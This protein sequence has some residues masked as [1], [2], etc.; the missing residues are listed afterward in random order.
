MRHSFA[1]IK[2]AAGPASLAQ[3]KKFTNAI[4]QEMK[5]A[6]VAGAKLG[7][8]GAVRDERLD[9]AILR[10]RCCPRVTHCPQHAELAL[11][12]LRPPLSRVAR[13]DSRHDDC[14]NRVL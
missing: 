3:V 7:V 10:L 1:W 2:G 6:N 14:I 9:V 13:P 5:K 11:R 4:R 8:D 12:R